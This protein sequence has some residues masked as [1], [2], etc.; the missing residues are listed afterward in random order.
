V[1]ERRRAG[2]LLAAALFALPLLA[3]VVRAFADVWRAPELVPQELGLRGV[4][5][6]LSGQ[7][8]EG[9]TTSLVVAL[10]VTALA[11]A[12]GWPAARVLGERR[13]RR[14]GLVF[15]L[16]A[17]PLLV[18]SF[19]T[20]QGLTEWFLRLGL[21]DTI[22][23]LVLAHLVL[24]L[25]YVIVLLLSGFGP[26]LTSLEEMGRVTGLD[27]LQRW[28]WVTLPAIAPTLGAAALLGFLVSWSE[29]G[30]SLA[31]GGGRPMLPLVLLPFVRTDPQVA[32]AISL[33]FLAPAIAALVLAARAARSPL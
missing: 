20:G 30:S 10:V 28:R 2:A 6:T 8:L 21:A 15:L 5:E 17:M 7:A 23:G 22:P 24:V 27:G 16:L 4:R 29:Y 11:I 12:V 18:P 3:L 32:A 19:A 25:P 1:A 31:V 33:L 26:S 9:F 14:P 13:L